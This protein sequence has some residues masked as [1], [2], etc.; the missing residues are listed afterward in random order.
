RT[1]SASIGGKGVA[2]W[3][4]DGRSTG[5]REPLRDRAMSPAYSAF[6]LRRGVVVTGL[7]AVTPL[8]LDAQTTWDAAVA[9]TS[10]VDWIRSFDASDFPV[11]IASEVKGFEP[12]AV[13]GPKDA[14]RLERNVV[15]AVAALR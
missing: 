13:V 8:G 1:S 9:G 3:G 11:R 10:G 4:A 14:R 5:S 7:G 6:P 2:L 12:A 15:F